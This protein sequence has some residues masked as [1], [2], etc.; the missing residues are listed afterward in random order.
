MYADE[1]L[2]L[3][4]SARVFPFHSLIQ[5][6]KEAVALG[7]ARGRAKGR[8]AERTSFATTKSG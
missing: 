4:V 5:D 8:R 7:F 2:L 1:F 6:S 3:I